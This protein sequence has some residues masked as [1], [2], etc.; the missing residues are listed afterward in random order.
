MGDWC[1]SSTV[2]MH[3]TEEG[4]LVTGSGGSIM[5]VV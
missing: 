3:E 2:A 1:L 4:D 5:N